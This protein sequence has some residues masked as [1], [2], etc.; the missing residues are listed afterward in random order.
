MTNVLLVRH[1]EHALQGRVLVGR[2]D[3]VAFSSRGR[4]QMRLLAQVLAEEPVAAIHSSPRLR[5]R[6]TATAI[7]ESHRLPVEIHAALDE[8]DYGNWTGMSFEQLA[9]LPGWR[10]WNEARAAVTPP[11]GESM[12][13]LQVRMLAY[14]HALPKS[15]ARKT[16]VAIS[17]A[18]PIRA[19]V[20]HATGLAL[21]DFARIDVLPGSITRLAFFERA[22]VGFDFLKVLTG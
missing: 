10:A 7:A 9:G 21:N 20:L 3:G 14:L 11:N 5:A 15:H 19:A 12:Q 6:D 17:H 22:F 1:A 16:V 2:S 13:A 4:E 8:I 18:E